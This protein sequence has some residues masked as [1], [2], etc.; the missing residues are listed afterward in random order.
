MVPLQIGAHL[1]ALAIMLHEKGAL[2][3][4]PMLHASDVLCLVLFCRELAKSHLSLELVAVFFLAAHHIRDPSLLKALAA[5]VKVT[6]PAVILEALSCLGSLL[7]ENPFRQQ[8]DGW[9]GG[10]SDELHEPALNT[11]GISSVSHSE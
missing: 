2:P 8:K 5:K 9:Q 6:K 7:A 10:S 1:Q 3:K 11:C 4:L